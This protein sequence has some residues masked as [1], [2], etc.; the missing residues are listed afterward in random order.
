MRVL[1][2]VGL[3]LFSALTAHAVEIPVG[4]TFSGLDVQTNNICRLQVLENRGNRIE[5]LFTIADSAKG[6]VHFEVINLAEDVDQYVKV[7][8]LAFEE[9]F[10]GSQE[11]KTI[12]AFKLKDFNVTQAA[13]K[14]V[15]VEI[16]RAH[17]EPN[18]VLTSVREI[19]SCPNLSLRLPPFKQPLK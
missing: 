1:L 13:F 8:P 14:R 4:A 10:F 11:I 17:N 16:R 2:F 7:Q 12:S 6:V 18:S 19:Y 15:H 5:V 9:N 3:I